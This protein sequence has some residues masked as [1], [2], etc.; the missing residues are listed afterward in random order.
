MQHTQRHAEVYSCSAGPHR[1]GPLAP[2]SPP[3]D[4]DL[5]PGVLAPGLEAWFRLPGSTPHLPSPAR[6]PPLALSSCSPSRRPR[7][8]AQLPQG[9]PRVSPAPS[10]LWGGICSQPAGFP[11]S[12]FQPSVGSTTVCSRPRPA[13]PGAGPGEQCPLSVPGPRELGRPLSSRSW[14]G[15]KFP[16]A[17]DLSLGW[18]RPGEAAEGWPGGSQGLGNQSQCPRYPHLHPQPP[19]QGRGIEVARGTEHQLLAGCGY[20]RGP[21]CTRW[22]HYFPALWKRSGDSERRRA[23]AKV[24]RPGSSP[25]RI[26]TRALSPQ[27]SS[28][29]PLPAWGPGLPDQGGRGQQP[30]SHQQVGLWA[31]P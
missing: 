10:I 4:R 19:G 6:R 13:A 18:R 7:P 5:T 29:Q 30:L 1:L 17:E 31:L 26:S 2:A 16:R 12:P 20:T 9:A 28:S 8:R 11:G 3:R 25:G 21:S 15:P 23:L 14:D 24:T 27:R 22:G